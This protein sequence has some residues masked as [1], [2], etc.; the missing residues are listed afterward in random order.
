VLIVAAIL[1]ATGLSIA[2]YGASTLSLVLA[3]ALLAVGGGFFHP[4]LIAHHVSLLPDR[5]GWAVA[6]F[7]FGFDAGIGIGA[8]LLGL[9]LDISGLTAL[10]LT[11]ALLT[12]MTLLFVPAMA[13]R[14]DS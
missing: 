1:M 12:L 7:Y 5:P 2:A 6:C 9:I 4:M 11:A 3:A 8:W 13:Q 14:N 10:F